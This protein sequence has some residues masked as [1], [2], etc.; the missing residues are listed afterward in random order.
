MTGFPI[1]K[2]KETMNMALDKLYPNDT[3][4]L[5]TFSGET[6]ILFPQPVP[7][8]RENLDLARQSLNNVSGMGGT[9]MMQAIR[10]ALKPSDAQGHVRIV[11]FMTDGLVGNDMAIISEVQ[12]HPNARIFSFGIGSSPNRFLLDKIAE[13]GRGAAEYVT[14][15]GDAAA[16]ASRFHERIRNPLLTDISIEW[17]GTPV[18]EIYPR[19]IPDVFSAEPVVICGRYSHGGEAKVRLHGISGTHDFQRD[20]HLT[21]PENELRH[22]VTPKLWARYRIHDLMAEDYEGIQRGNPRVEVRKAITQLGLQYGL[23]TQFTSFVAVEDRIANEGGK[24]V[25]VQVPVEMPEGLSYEGIFGDS[26]AQSQRQLQLP[27]VR[28]P[29][30]D[31]SGPS[32]GGGSFGGFAV[33]SSGGSTGTAKREPAIIG[34]NVQESKL[35]NKIDP[36]YPQLAKRAHVS[37]SVILI[38]DIDE[39]GNVSKVRVASGHPLLNDAAIDAVKQWK[40]SPT[41]FNGLPVPVNAT[42]TV[43]FSPGAAS[44]SQVAQPRVDLAVAK[45]LADL[46]GG[47]PANDGTFIQKKK[48][49]LELSV[50]GRSEEVMAKLR[51]L[52]FDVISLPTE[53]T[54]IVGKM[55]V[56]KLELL[57][58]IDAVRYIA[59]YRQ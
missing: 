46:K 43:A 14:L 20:I 19:R 9:E 16:A 7:A 2:A 10:A 18:S 57:L 1:E 42:V 13:E 22:E 50:A 28:T 24:Q 17:S 6:R 45:I 48:A 15:E 52:G 53:S 11:C 12:K 41:I 33:G 55:P 47:R 23:M 54:K 25:T 40:Y 34:G 39:K 5:I 26:G 59:P 29:F 37:G 21:L 30:G 38:V 44:K 31:I 8:T 3:F 35:V 27:V 51:S 36:V 58:D 56:E 32:G 4:N 49:K